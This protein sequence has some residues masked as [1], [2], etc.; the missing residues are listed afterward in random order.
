MSLHP[1]EPDPVPA[2]TARIAHAAFPAGNPYHTSSYEAGSS[3][4]AVKHFDRSGLPVH[5]KSGSESLVRSEHRFSQW[6]P[7]YGRETPL[8]SFT[9][10]AEEPA[11]C[12]SV[13]G[14]T[15]RC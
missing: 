7:W 6:I 9:V 3:A 5:G 8:S 12:G 13:W 10:I 14:V 11:S 15:S 1:H 2:K 4:I